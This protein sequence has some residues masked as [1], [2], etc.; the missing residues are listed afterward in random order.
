M[1]SIDR[2]KVDEY[3]DQLASPCFPGPACGSAAATVAAMA[4]ALLEMSYA[5]TMQK[6]EQKSDLVPSLKDASA[7]RKHC[8]NLATEDMQA[9]AEVVRAA[10]TKQ[11]LPG[12]YEAGMQKAT[13]TLAAIVAN[14]QA[15]LKL[16]ESLVDICYVKVL[17][18]LGGSAYLAA[19]AAAAA[20]Q[21]VQ[22]NLGL[23]QDELYKENVLNF[24]LESYRN[25]S[26]AKERIIAAIAERS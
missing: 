24:V 13:D 18:D 14:C 21:G 26:A 15:M 12:Q 8:L 9:Y 5:V 22:V 19:A 17:G 20:K 4:A 3:L 10:K 7:I 25:S 16:I 11:E 1:Y 23:V 2:L 6:D